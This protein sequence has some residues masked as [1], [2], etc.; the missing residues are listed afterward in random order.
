MVNGDLLSPGAFGTL[1]NGAT[2]SAPFASYVLGISDASAFEAPGR[3]LAASQV[4]T[5]LCA[6]SHLFKGSSAHFESCIAHGTRKNPL[7]KKN[8][9][10]DY[11]GQYRTRTCDLFHV[12]ETL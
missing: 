11:G 7:L 8:P 10:L 3:P 5:T 12:K 9:S 6:S 1:T 2:D 4:A